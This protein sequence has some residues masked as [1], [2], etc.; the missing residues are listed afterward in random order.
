MTL[1][2]FYER[3]KMET[4]SY[5][6]YKEFFDQMKEYVSNLSKAMAFHA[7]VLHHDY[8]KKPANWYVG[9]KEKKEVPVLKIVQTN[10]GKRVYQTRDYMG[11]QKFL[12]TF[13]TGDDKKFF[14][15]F[16]PSD[17]D[18]C[19]FLNNAVLKRYNIDDTSDYNVYGLAAVF[20]EILKEFSLKDSYSFDS[21]V[22]DPD[23]RTLKQN[24]FIEAF[25]LHLES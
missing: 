18:G 21:L 14:I 22:I 13:R 8:K 11:K 17:K 6:Q 3:D 24:G 4:F 16:D 12:F 10:L 5:E 1:R 9:E 2:F 20:D 25:L 7:F 23:I 19:I 15:F